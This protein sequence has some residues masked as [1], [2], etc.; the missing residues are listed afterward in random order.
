MPAAT[1]IANREINR[2]TG[3]EEI[4]ASHGID[5]ATDQEFQVPQV[6]PRVLGATFDREYGEYVLD[7]D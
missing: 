6:D 1:I 5:L 3:L 7:F 2:R 4:I